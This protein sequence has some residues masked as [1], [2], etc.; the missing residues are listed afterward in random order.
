MVL[1]SCSVLSNAGIFSG[2]KRPPSSES[3]FRIAWEALATALL[4]VLL[5]KISI[6][7]SPHR[8]PGRLNFS[9]DFHPVNRTLQNRALPDSVGHVKDS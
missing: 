1:N 8:L 7:Q 9:Y 4:L 2:T 3:P 5:Y 6:S